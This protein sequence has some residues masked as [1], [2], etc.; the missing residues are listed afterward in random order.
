MK[1]IAK[2]KL[3]DMLTQAVADM[4]K[5]GFDSPDRLQG[6]ISKLR[7][8]ATQDAGTQAQ[9]VQR[10]RLSLGVLYTRWVSN[11]AILKYHPGIERTTLKVIEPRLRAV[12]DRRILASAD[13]IKLNREQAIEK[14]L[15]R[16]SGWATSI[17]SG[18]SKVVDRLDVKSHVA[19]TMR[20]ASYETRRLE[21]DQGHKMLSN[22]SAVIA[23]QTGAIA[24]KWRHVHQ[25]GYDG[26][27]EHEAR[28]GVW[29]VLRES[30]ATQRGYMKHGPYSDSVPQPGEEVFCRC[31]WE[32][33][34]SLVD[35]PDELLT[36]KGLEAKRVT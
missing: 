32:Y 31:W 11:G 33:A 29:F 3:W 25:S 14:T 12:L 10:L 8:A 28:D 34:D 19:K 6:W 7:D 30:W 36:V 26:R 35:V 17:P 15:S 4:T 23:E 5:H 18:G 22:I 16:F 2:V 27:P 24:A 1:Q 9:A 21:I 13:L 20:T